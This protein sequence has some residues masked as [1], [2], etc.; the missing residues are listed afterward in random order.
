[1]RGGGEGGDGANHPVLRNFNPRP[2]SHQCSFDIQL[3]QIINY[4]VRKAALSR[5]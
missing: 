5:K 4:S 3:G 2:S 1:M